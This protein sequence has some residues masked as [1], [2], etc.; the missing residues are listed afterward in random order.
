G[1][2]EQRW[3]SPPAMTR[4]LA[5]MGEVHWR[6]PLQAPVAVAMGAPVSPSTATSWLLLTYQTTASDLPSVVVAMGEV[7]APASAA[8]PTTRGA[9]GA[10]AGS[11]TD[12]ITLPLGP[13]DGHCAP[14][15]VEK[16]TCTPS[17]VV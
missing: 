13:P 2:Q 8:H 4:P 10:P 1:D 11:S 15:S 5:A 16:T 14:L 6:T 3:P 7:T 12:M 17:A 9:G